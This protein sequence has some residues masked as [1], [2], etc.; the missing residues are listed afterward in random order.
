MFMT[1]LPE[2]ESW[3]CSEL[4]KCRNN[5]TR[6]GTAPS[7]NPPALRSEVA[8]SQVYFIAISGQFGHR[9]GQTAGKTRPWQ[10]P[11]LL[12]VKDEQVGLVELRIPSS[13][14]VRVGR[15]AKQEY[16]NAMTDFNKAIG[17]ARLLTATGELF[18][19][20]SGIMT[21]P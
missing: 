20:L 6:L 1:T 19:T 18:T 13:V 2:V 14:R 3:F 21:P 12:K 4:N 16:D 5:L 8:S 15:H 17:K 11:K 7:F 9:L 10:T